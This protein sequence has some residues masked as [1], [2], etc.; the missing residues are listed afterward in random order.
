MNVLWLV[1]LALSVATTCESKKTGRLTSGFD[2]KRLKYGK[3]ATEQQEQ[4]VNH[5]FAQ[6]GDAFEAES[7]KIAYTNEK[8]AKIFF[9][10]YNF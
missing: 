6:I 4:S 2:D 5:V 1:V 7:E 3:D 9:K 8:R 10:Y